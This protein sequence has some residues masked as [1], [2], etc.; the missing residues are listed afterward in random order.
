MAN[1]EKWTRP[2]WN[3]I[4]AVLSE[5]EIQKVS[6]LSLDEEAGEPVQAALDMSADMFRGALQAKSVR[7]DVRPHYV[8]RAY[9]YF[10]LTYA[11]MLMWS[12]FPNSPA[13]AMDDVRRKEADTALDM[14]KNPKLDALPPD[15]SDVKEGDPYFEEVQKEIEEQSRQ[16]GFSTGSV[17]NRF[18]RT[19]M[20]TDWGYFKGWR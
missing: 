1:V 11:R 2:G 18:Q 5:D 16:A 4:R 13:Y 8:P 6:E 14:L 17:K 20:W 9:M 10:V 3:D 12:R 15:Y 7:L 19:A